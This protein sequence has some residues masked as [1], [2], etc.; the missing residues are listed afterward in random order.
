MKLDFISKYA[1]VTYG[2][3]YMYK[4]MVQKSTKNEYMEHSV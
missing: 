4:Y 3:K 1:N 2:A